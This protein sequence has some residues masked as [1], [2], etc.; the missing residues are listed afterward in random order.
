M[1]LL[2]PIYIIQYEE[3]QQ[4]TNQ[5]GHTVYQQVPH[6][7][8]CRTKKE[9]INIIEDIFLFQK[10]PNFVVDTRYEAID[11]AEGATIN[12]ADIK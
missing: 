1:Q 6:Q 12:N 7:Q 2:T 5:T 8:E 10:R 11:T 9:L 3:I 4:V